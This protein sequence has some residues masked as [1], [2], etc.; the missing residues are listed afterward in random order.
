MQWQIKVEKGSN[1][2]EEDAKNIARNITQTNTN[3]ELFKT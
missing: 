3:K 1:K 2:H